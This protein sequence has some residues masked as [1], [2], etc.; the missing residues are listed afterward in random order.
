MQIKNKLVKTENEAT[1]LSR[2]VVIPHDVVDG[3]VKAAMIEARD[4]LQSE[5]DNHYKDGTYLHPDDI[6]NNRELIYCMNKLI[7]YY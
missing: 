7:A 5:I 2:G 1:H 4:Y 3:I 6:P